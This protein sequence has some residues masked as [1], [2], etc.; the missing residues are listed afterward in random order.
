[1]PRPAGDG[2]GWR[3]AALPAIADAWT[4]CAV[5]DQPLCRTERAAQS[6]A[7][8]FAPRGRVT[9]VPMVLRDAVAGAAAVSSPQPPPQ[10]F[11]LW[12]PLQSW[13]TW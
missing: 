8:R 5:A 2:A 12:Q 6:R 10:L 1:M 4:D 13:P 11:V 9:T 7:M 3:G